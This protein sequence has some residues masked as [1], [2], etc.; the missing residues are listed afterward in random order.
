[1]PAVRLVD[2]EEYPDVALNEPET[3]IHRPNPVELVSLF[4][5]LVDVFSASECL[6]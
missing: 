5:R 3:M 4:V 2:F 6:A 1:M